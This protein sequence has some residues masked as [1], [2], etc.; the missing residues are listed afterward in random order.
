MFGGGVG[1]C[2][3]GED[4]VSVGKCVCGVVD[5]GGVFGTR[6]RTRVAMFV[7]GG[8]RRCDEGVGRCDESVGGGDGCVVG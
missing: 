4:L 1:V 6:R 3:C 2:G 5:E 7:R 8:R